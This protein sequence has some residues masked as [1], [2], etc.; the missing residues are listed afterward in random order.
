MQ[1]RLRDTTE[2]G[3]RTAGD[4]LGSYL[5]RI[6][7]HDLLCSNAEADLSGR[8]LDGDDEA[9]RKL[10]ESN[11]RLVVSIARGYMRCGLELS[12]LI[13]EGNLGLMRAAQ[14]FD[15]A[16]FGTRFSTYATPWIKNHIAR[17]L[18]EKGAP[19]RL[20]E[21][22]LQKQRALA[23]ART[24]VR[25]AHGREPAVEELATFMDLKSKTVDELSTVPKS[26]ISGDLPVGEEGQSTLFDLLA[27]EDQEFE[28][29]TM[30]S[31]TWS[32]V[33]ALVND[34]NSTERSV[35]ESRY[36]LNG[37]T[38]QTLREIAESLNVTRERVRQIHNRALTKLR[39]QARRLL[40]DEPQGK[41]THRATLKGRLHSPAN[42]PY[43][44][45][46]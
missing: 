15:A 5:D 12:D 9:C 37:K 2:L 4:A 3:Q 11:L 46:A 24:H 43:A 45:T 6:A 22:A 28:E 32:R 18:Q 14:T 7:G 31:A 34:L 36:G 42:E 30:Q 33:E 21:S 40:L 29:S 26:V 35:V 1:T 8:T 10:V 17:A 44:Q 27:D 19:I 16:R 13:Q 39:H 20:P 23:N 38:A 25:T 41:G